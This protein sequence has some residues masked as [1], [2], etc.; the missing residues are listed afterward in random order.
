M[1]WW[2]FYVFK[3][4]SIIIP[5]RPNPPQIKLNNSK[6]WDFEQI[7]ILLLESII[8]NYTIEYI[9]DSSDVIPCAFTLIVPPTENEEYDYIV[10][11]ALP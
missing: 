10:I 1:S 11:G 9:I 8:V 7:L 6:F 2:F 4:T 5:N 3:V